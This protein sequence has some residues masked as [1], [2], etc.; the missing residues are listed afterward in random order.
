MTLTVDD[1]SGE[2]KTVVVPVHLD[3]KKKKATPKKSEDAPAPQPK[4]RP[5]M[6]PVFMRFLQSG[7][8]TELRE[9]P[10]VKRVFKNYVFVKVVELNGRTIHVDKAVWMQ[11]R[12]VGIMPP[13]YWD[14]EVVNGL[15][16]AL[17]AGPQKAIIFTDGSRPFVVNDLV[18]LE[19][20]W[21]SLG[22]I[23]NSLYSKPREYQE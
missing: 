10:D 14:D 13:N 15:Q 22:R 2:A 5:T 17:K 16:E 9:Y 1:G 3:G 6:D 8:I 21:N 11:K 20:D 18:F 12:I 4:Q 7:D 19:D 23:F